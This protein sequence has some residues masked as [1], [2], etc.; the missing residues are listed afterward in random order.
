MLYFYCTVSCQVKYSNVRQ[1]NTDDFR[2]QYMWTGVGELIK[3]M[4]LS[5]FT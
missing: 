3:L 2:Y 1:E 4:N 5:D